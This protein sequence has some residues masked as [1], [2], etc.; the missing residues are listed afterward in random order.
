MRLF[1]IAHFSTNKASPSWNDSELRRMGGLLFLGH[2]Q[3]FGCKIFA[4]F[5]V[6]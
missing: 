5:A 2:E 1:K 4:A 6:K 3:Q